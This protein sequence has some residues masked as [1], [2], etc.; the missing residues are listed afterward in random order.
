MR[1]AFSGFQLDATVTAVGKAVAGSLCEKTVVGAL[2]LNVQTMGPSDICNDG[3][4]KRGTPLVY[5]KFV[6]ATSGIFSSSSS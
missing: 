5:I 4:L 2:Y 1:R 3:T 6:P